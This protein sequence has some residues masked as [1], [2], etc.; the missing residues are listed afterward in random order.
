MNPHSGPK[1]GRGANGMPGDALRE[2]LP[3]VEPSAVE[4]EAAEVQPGFFTPFNIVMLG[5][6]LAL[7]AFL[8]VKFNPAELWNIV[9]AGLGL[10]FVIFIHE[11]GHFLAAKWCGVRVTTF[12][13][14]FGAP[15]PGCHFT[16]GET[17][18]KLAILP[19]GGYVQ[20]VGQIDGDESSDG[21]EDD[22]GSYRTKTVGQRML[23]I[24]A[25]VIMNAILAVICF[26]AVY[27]GPGRVHPAGVIDSVDA[28]GPVF[29]KG[30]KSGAQILKIGDVDDPN[31]DDLKYTVIFSTSGE[32]IPLIYQVPAEAPVTTEIESRKDKS[33]KTRAIGVRAPAKLQLVSKRDAHEG[34]YLA[35]TSAAEAKFQPGDVIVAMTDPQHPETV[36]EIPDDP[37]FPGHGQRDYFEFMRRLQ[38]LAGKEIVVR[39]K[40]NT[41]ED[42]HEV[43]LKVAPMFRLNPGIVMTMGPIL[44][45]REGSDAAGKVRGPDAEKKLA[46]DRID[47][48]SVRDPG[49]EKHTLEFDYKDGTLDP[50]RLPFQLR[51]WSHRL[52]E[53]GY[54]GDRVVTL[55]LRRHSEVPFGDDT[56]KE[57]VEIKWERN[58]RFDRVGPLSV[59]SPMPIPE[60]GIAYQVRAVVRAVADPDSKLKPDDVIKN[61]RFDVKTFKEDKSYPW[62]FKNDLD[63][64]QWAFVGS[65]LFD[66]PERI[67]NLTYKV[68]RGEETLEVAVPLSIDKTWPL[69]ER[70]WLFLADTR[71]VT[72]DNSLKAVQ[73]G[74]KDTY[75]KL[76]ETF[77]TL[78]GIVLGDIS[79]DVIGGPITIAVATYHFAGM[80][81]AEFAFFLGWISIS[82]AVVNFLPIP[83]LDGG[84]MVFLIYEKIRGQ[85][86]SEGVRIGATYVGL[87]LILCLMVFVVYLDISRLFF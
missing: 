13:I 52:D 61:I 81:F 70:G 8:L 32:K 47:K 22:P 31:F 46:G 60:L 5:M 29:K 1:T 10:S 51:Q 30:V 27:Q 56:K 15:I 48:V 7:I 82:L 45:V 28:N 54:K 40:R 41:D 38:L 84:H 18:Y 43:D 19:L 50:E 71:R 33:D 17:T 11:L 3:P 69:T 23:I 63:E 58:R 73:L 12:S 87:A 20:M 67:T 26:I 25:G 44:S 80:D 35:G 65:L 78:R 66:T 57:T 83:V 53:I 76:M 42:V 72:A 34:P 49:N 37:R 62:R 39:V 75:Q 68:K 14:G 21:S 86:A 24:S 64:G 79:A 6:L 9:K 59:N 74:L 55:H 4:P 2:G 77:L 36:T 85:P 16:W